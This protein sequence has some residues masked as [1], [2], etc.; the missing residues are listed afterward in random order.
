MNF[1]K[2]SLEGDRQIYIEIHKFSLKLVMPSNKLF[3][4]HIEHPLFVLIYIGMSLYFICTN[5]YF[6]CTT[7]CWY[8]FVF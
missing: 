6:V 3:I 2:T 1:T 7:L 8:K 5:S 4:T